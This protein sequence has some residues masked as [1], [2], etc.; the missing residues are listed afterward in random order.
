MKRLLILFAAFSMSFMV[1]AQEN[2]MESQETMSKTNDHVMMKNGIMMIVKGDQ[3]MKMDQDLT[4]SDGTVVSKTGVVKTPDGTTMVL[5]NGEMIDMSGKKMR[6]VKMRNH[7]M[8]NDGKMML[9]KESSRSELNQE[10]TLDNGTVITPSGMVKTKDGKTMQLRDGEKLDM[11]GM[12]I[13]KNNGRT[14]NFD[15]IR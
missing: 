6:S 12:L 4:L 2:K 9:V 13:K 11:N 10:M 3:M 14:T 7:M 5:R 8:M 1:N 15:T